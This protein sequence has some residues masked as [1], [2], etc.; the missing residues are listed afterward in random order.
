MTS[1]ARPVSVLLLGLLSVACGAAQAAPPTKAEREIE[2]LIAGLGE[3]GCEFERN[4]DWHD[5]GAAQAHLRSK[6]AW[7]RKRGLAKSAEQ[8][9]ERGAS[10]S[11]LS[12]RHYRVR[13]PGKPVTESGIWFRAQL[14]R[15]RGPPGG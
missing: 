6:Y 10:A 12:G 3:S 1:L 13:C 7:L 14:T 2:A 5:A 11:S 9:I 15:L 8:F 4:G